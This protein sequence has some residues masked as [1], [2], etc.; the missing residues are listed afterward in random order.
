MTM[1]DLKD[2]IERRFKADIRAHFDQERRSGCFASLPSEL[3]P[4]LAGAL[5]QQGI[6]RLYTH[7]A[8]AFT[9]ISTATDTLLVSS[10][11]SGKTLAFFLPILDRYL[12]AAAPFSVLLLYPTKALSRDQEGKLGALMKAVQCDSR[13]GTFDGD[14]PQDERARIQRSGDFVITNPD[15]LHAGLLP[16]HFRKWKT[17]LARLRYVVI[18]E[19]HIY[20]GAFGSHVSNVF[21]RLQRVCA[22]Y[23]C[24]PTFV[25]SSATVGN[26]LQHAKAL[27]HR[28]FQLVSRD[29][30][31]H[32][33][34]SFFLLNPP[35]MSSLG[36]TLYRRGTSSVAVPL[37]REACRRKIRTIC[38]CRSRQE[39]ER[40]RRA[41]IDR[42]PMLRSLVKPYRGGLLPN[43]RRQLER[44]L[45]EGRLTAIITTN[46]LELGIDIGDLELCILSGYPGTMA[47]FRQR[48]GRVGRQNRP[49]LVVFIAR[50]NPIDQYLV[51]HPDFISQAPVEEALLNADN[52]YIVLQ[53]LP[54]MAHEH[55]LRELE[56][57]FDPDIYQ[58]A[59][60]LLIKNGTV[61]PYRD[62]LRY[63]LRDYPARGVS[64]RGLTD[65]NVEIYCGS[66]VIGELD[67]IG[68]RGTLYK[69]AIYLHLGK[70]YLSLELDLD[71]KLCRVAEVDVDYFTEA[72]W[73]GRLELI[74][75]DREQSLNG[76]CLHFGPIHCNRQPKLYKKIRER[77]FENIGYGPI[78]LAPFEYDTTGFSLL[79]PTNWLDALNATDR[80]F[81]GAAL[82]GL[83]YLLRHTAPALCMADSGDLDTDV[84]LVSLDENRWCNALFMFD[85]IEG[86]VG[87]TEKVFEKVTVC[88]EICR[89]VLDSCECR[90]GC[91]S[92]VPSL[93]PGAGGGE[94]ETLLIESD[95]A[96]V[97]TRSLLTVLLDGRIEIPQVSFFRT[98]INAV[99]DILPE[100]ERKSE[101][102]RKLERAASILKRKRERIH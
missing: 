49:S 55:P 92:C 80:R 44:D 50:D 102:R 63:A 21:R 40:L 77:S 90:A 7:Q 36:H 76:A 86:G 46:A 98:P 78:T 62:T 33:A 38:F 74:E 1:R 18:D 52:P 48:S 87:Y 30:S 61:V 60:E 26:P 71:Q 95:A 64:L 2:F 43:E 8:E 35:L 41:V 42:H 54:C 58:Q 9:H 12:K 67:P 97:C 47:S 56:V 59:C 82:F 57:G 83:G 19:V 69:D 79:P 81:P 13:L 66:E 3:H 34:R 22:L 28:D 45:A 25:C 51:H 85:T 53:H 10:T 17:F 100:D 91:P 29:G 70:R 75:V 68:A 99:T 72:Q 31:P 23:G 4:G 96:I 11:A 15:M 93:P 84:S 5:R 88:L 94:L 14:T 37:I 65:H 16:N 20:R 101:I 73:E 27:T 6:E 39:V 24:H 32:S 89:Q